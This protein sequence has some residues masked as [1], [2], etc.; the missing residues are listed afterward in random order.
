MRTLVRVKAFDG[1]RSVRRLVAPLALVMA[2]AAFAISIVALTRSGHMAKVAAPKTSTTIATLKACET[3]P[4]N[5]ADTSRRFTKSDWRRITLARSTSRGRGP[6][7][8]SSDR[9]H[10]RT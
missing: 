4:S 8:W 3:T 5:D 2:V 10:R 1:R 7:C 6:M 9:S